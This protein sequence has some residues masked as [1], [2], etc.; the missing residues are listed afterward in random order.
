MGGVAGR[1]VVGGVPTAHWSG[2]KAGGGEA[3]RDGV[4]LKMSTANFF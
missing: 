3:S 4:R 2:Q 1:V